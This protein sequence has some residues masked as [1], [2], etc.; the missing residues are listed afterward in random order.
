[1]VVRL[2]LTSSRSYKNYRSVNFAHKN[3]AKIYTHLPLP[4]FIWVAELSLKNFFLEDRVF[5]E[6]IIDATAARHAGINSLIA[7]HYPGYLGIR[8]P[9]EPLS[10]IFNMLEMYY[11]ELSMTYPLYKNNLILGGI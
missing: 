10:T 5:G 1:M 3:L 2:F 11:K 4:K 6:I 8:F 9:E 7:V